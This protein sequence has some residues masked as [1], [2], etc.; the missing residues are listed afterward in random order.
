MPD[1]PDQNEPE[2]PLAYSYERFST[3]GQMKGDSTRR[4]KTGAEKFAQNHSYR[5]V[6]SY[7]DFGVSAYRGKNKLEGA[8]A[9]FLQAVN[10]GKVRKG[11]ILIVESLDRISREKPRIALPWF[12]NL[13]NA[14]IKIGTVTDNKIYDPETVNDMDLMGSLFVMSRANE[15]SE[16]KAFRV[17]ESWVGRR[18]KRVNGAICPSWLY[19]DPKTG[20]YKTHDDRVNVVKEIFNLTMAGVGAY[21]ISRMLNERKEPLW[22]NAVGKKVEK[23]KGW[24]PTTVYNILTNRAVLG[25]RQYGAVDED[26]KKVKV[27]EEFKGDY[28]PVIDEDVW[29]RAQVARKKSKAGAKG[30]LLS[31]LLDDIA[32]CNHCRERMRIKTSQVSEGRPDAGRMYRYLVCSNADAKRGC[33]GVGRWNYDEVEKA[34]LDHVPEYKLHEI[35]ARTDEESEI[36]NTGKE[37]GTVVFKLGELEKRQNRMVHELSLTDQDDPLLDVYRKNLREV[38]NEVRKAK[39][40]MEGLLELK[41]DLESQQDYRGGGEAAI[42][43]LRADL[44]G[45]TLTDDEK[46]KLRARLSAAL[47]SFIDF[48]WFDGQEETFDVILMGGMIVHKFRKMAPKGRGRVRR[49]EYVGSV[50]VSS[51]LVM[52]GHMVPEAFTNLT[53]NDNIEGADPE[54]V[55][56][57]TRLIASAKKSGE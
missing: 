42:K 44:E 25:F 13:L 17:R 27:G 45:S 50:D 21:T 48:V 52:G 39:E 16:R 40:Q 28:P 37:I 5:L 54:R 22:D 11:S 2:M 3:R 34:I 14:G 49:I 56:L 36:Q 43:Q 1:Q 30:K 51:P 32:E 7:H 26:G 53:K 10:D 47:R 57:F 41:A 23:R 29:L 9:D 4:Q 38:V 19:L 35:F 12:L 15:E 55:E 46:Y 31:N 20:T 6:K 24:H 33:T 8:L 18:E